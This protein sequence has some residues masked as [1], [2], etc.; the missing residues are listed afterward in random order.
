MHLRHSHRTG[1]LTRTPMLT[2][3]MSCNPVLTIS[4]HLDIF[5]AHQRSLRVLS[6]A[7][8]F[9][10]TLGRPSSLSGASLSDPCA[11]LPCHWQ[12]ICWSKLMPIGFLQRP[13]LL[14]L[15]KS[16]SLSSCNRQFFFVPYFFPFTFF[17]TGAYRSFRFFEPLLH[18]PQF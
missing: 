9:R 13:R 12:M 11:L 16:L 1:F 4:W 5:L 7:G 2:S 6:P 8:D 15:H 18:S 17:G 3:F 14:N 10:D